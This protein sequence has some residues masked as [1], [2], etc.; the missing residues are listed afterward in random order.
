MKGV[1]FFLEASGRPVH[2]RHLATGWCMLDM[3]KHCIEKARSPI[4]EDEALVLIGD[5]QCRSAPHCQGPSVTWLVNTSH[6][7]GLLPVIPRRTPPPLQ[8]LTRGFAQAD[9]G[10]TCDSTQPRNCPTLLH[11]D[12]SGRLLYSG[13]TRAHLRCAHWSSTA[14][15]EADAGAVAAGART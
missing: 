6:L 4:K 12:A 1:V 10:A 7:H 2:L 15:A 11:H 13:R 14:M 9:L 8:F 3:Q 5:A